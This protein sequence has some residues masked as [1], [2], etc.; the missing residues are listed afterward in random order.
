MKV[1]IIIPIYNVES[2]IANCLHSVFNQTYKDLEII[3]VDDCGTDKSMDVAKEIIRKYK[4]D[5]HIIIEHHTYNKGLSA[6]RNTGIKK[7]TGEFIYFLDSDD[8]ISNDCI[9]RLMFPILQGNHVDFSIADYKV[10]GTNQIY[11]PLLLEEGI[12]KGNIN[13]INSYCKKEWYVMAV[14]KLINKSFLLKNNLFFKED[15]LHEDELWSF[16]LASCAESMYVIQEKTYFYYIRNNS[17]TTAP[18]KKNFDA[19][20]TI[21]QEINNTINLHKL[22]HNI[23]V[24]NLIEGLKI[25]TF[26]KKYR[27]KYKYN[28][29]YIYKE[30]YRN[31]STSISLKQLIQTYPSKVLWEVQYYLPPKIGYYYCI[32]LIRLFYILK[33]GL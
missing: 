18:K 8:T 30:S 6:A 20:S 19:T 32:I 23:E 15:L 28:L 7:S 24:Y 29:Y 25:S 27:F 5:F 33:Y 16:Q 1:S 10:I 9:E 21:I 12:I 17:I 26:I 31:R 13:I 4:N 14:N 22:C 2:Y 11:P 3:L